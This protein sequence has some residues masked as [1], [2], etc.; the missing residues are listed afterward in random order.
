[1]SNNGLKKWRDDRPNL[2][3]NHRVFVQNII[4][5][6]FEDLYEKNDIERIKFEIMEKYYPI[7]MIPFSENAT[8]DKMADIQVFAINE[9]ELMNYDNDLVMDETIKEISSRLQD[10]IQ[11]EI[12]SK[13]GYDNTKWQKDKNQ[14]KDTLYVANYDGCRK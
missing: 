13:W 7:G 2:K 10:P 8:I 12:W 3:P 6:L 5:E 4:E 11:K 9:V 14:Q 1:M